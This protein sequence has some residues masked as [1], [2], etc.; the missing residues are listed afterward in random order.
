[1]E[2]IVD[3]I[4]QAVAR[5]GLSLT[6]MRQLLEP[7]STDVYDAALDHFVAAGDRRWWWEDFRQAGKSVSFD[8]GQ[9]WRRVP[10]ITP[11]SDELIWFIAEDGSLPHYPVFETTPKIASLVIGECYGFEYYLIA[12]DLSWL[13]CENHHNVLCA[14]GALVEAR[15]KMVA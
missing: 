6:A 12:Q 10:Q 7:H 13:L 14:V 15:L 1:M 11:A 3:E 2:T 4:N 8:D 5:L 9:G